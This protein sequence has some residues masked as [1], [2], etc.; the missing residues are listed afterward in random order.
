MLSGK[1]NQTVHNT[2]NKIKLNN[3]QHYHQ[4]QTKQCIIISR[5]SNEAMHNVIREIKPG[6]A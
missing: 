1:S 2:I 4:S 6:D 3:A 5:K